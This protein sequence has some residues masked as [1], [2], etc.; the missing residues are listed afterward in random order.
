MDYWCGGSLLDRLHSDLALA[1][2]VGRPPLGMLMF[3]GVRLGGSFLLPTP[4]RWG[5]GHP[6]LRGTTW[7]TGAQGGAARGPAGVDR[8]G[9][10]AEAEGGGNTPVHSGRQGSGG[11]SDAPPPTG[12]AG[13]ALPGQG[14]GG[15]AP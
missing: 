9:E 3:L 6:Y 10:P 15:G 7:C 2:C 8:S 4:W 14:A 13:R 11:A 12:A 5:F 1:R